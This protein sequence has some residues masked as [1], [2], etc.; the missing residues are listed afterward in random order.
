M[1]I[2]AVGALIDTMTPETATQV[3]S[4]LPRADRKLIE[5]FAAMSDSEID[6]VPLRKKR[7]MMGRMIAAFE[8]IAALS[9]GAN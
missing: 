7:R 3:W 2:N 9:Q 8:R 6:A 1:N 5:Y 4:K